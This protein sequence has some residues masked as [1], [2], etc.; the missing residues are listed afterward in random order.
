MLR[1]SRSRVSALEQVVRLEEEQVS[2]EELHLSHEQDD[3]LAVQRRLEDEDSSRYEIMVDLF[4]IRLQDLASLFCSHKF[5]GISLRRRSLLDRTTHP[6][7]VVMDERFE[8]WW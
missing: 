8:H 3:A 6:R 5:R 2:S 1:A 7:M 4:S